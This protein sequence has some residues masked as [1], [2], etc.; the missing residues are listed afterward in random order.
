MAT[1]KLTDSQEKSIVLNS[2]H[3]LLEMLNICTAAQLEVYGKMYP[4]GPSD[5]QIQW[6]I[7]QIE[8]TILKGNVDQERLKDINSL[9][10]AYKKEAEDKHDLLHLEIKR[11]SNELVEAEDRINKLS[12]PIN[13]QSADVQERLDWLQALEDAGVDNWDGYSYARQS[14]HESEE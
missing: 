13:V 11:L 10:E 8:R 3:R 7:Q 1:I 9:F 2:R 5:D 12:N 6:A 14:L 4:N